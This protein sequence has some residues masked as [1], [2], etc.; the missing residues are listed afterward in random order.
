QVVRSKS[1]A[2]WLVALACFG[3]FLLAWA[4]YYCPWGASWLPRLPGSR[5][6]LE[7]AVPVPPSWYADG[8]PG[9]YRWALIYAKMAPCERDCEQHLTR[10]L[11]VHLALGRDQDRTQRM[12]WIADRQPGFA[13]PELAV[14]RLD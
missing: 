10:L 2:P 7:P 1:L 6:L 13:D 9:P 4:L 8:A 14:H 11:Q 5:E 3:P 12:L